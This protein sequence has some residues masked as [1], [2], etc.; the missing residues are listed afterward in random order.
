MIP[1]YLGGTC[2]QGSTERWLL[3]AQNSQY[4]VDKC[5][6]APAYGDSAEAHG[7]F[8]ER[9]FRTELDLYQP[10]LCPK[11]RVSAGARSLSTFGAE[12]LSIVFVHGLHGHPISS[13]RCSGSAECWPAAYLANSVT[14]ARIMS[15]G[16]DAVLTQHAPPI[17][18]D[19]A[20]EL[21]K[22]LANARQSVEAGRPILFVAH[23]FGGLVAKAVR[24]Q[25]SS[26]F[27]ALTDLR[28]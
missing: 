20:A 1:L 18:S 14:D 23:G 17:I 2:K 8:T 10:A 4:H 24:S 7:N 11:H 9:N 27:L 21:L 19:F 28:L 25:K 6:A 16:Y 5:T 3:P 26:L 12:N 13:W 15:F 22:L